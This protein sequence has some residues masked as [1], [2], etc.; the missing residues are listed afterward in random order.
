MCVCLF[1]GLFCLLCVP[2]TICN[3]KAMKKHKWKTYYLFLEVLYFHIVCISIRTQLKI[4][5]R[6]IHKR[7]KQQQQKKNKRKGRQAHLLWKI[8][9]CLSPCFKFSIF[10]RISYF[11]NNNMW[12]DTL[13]ECEEH[14][15]SCTWFLL[16]VWIVFGWLV[17]YAHLCLATLL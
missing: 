16:C 11:N 8:S 6:R 10:L 17:N 13:R 1:S 2:Y 4:G 14:T 3:T 7:Q 12:T 15:V 5:I 9:V